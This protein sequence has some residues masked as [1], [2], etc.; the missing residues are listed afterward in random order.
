MLLLEMNKEEGIMDV[1][2]ELPFDKHVAFVEGLIE[3]AARK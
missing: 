2:T 3:R 1:I